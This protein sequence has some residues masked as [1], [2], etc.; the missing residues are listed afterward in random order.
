MK[1]VYSILIVGIFCIPSFGKI[2]TYFSN[3]DVLSHVLESKK[4]AENK[5]LKGLELVSVEVEREGKMLESQYT[6]SLQYTALGFSL[7]TCRVT[8][9]VSIEVRT[10]GIGGTPRVTVSE[11]TDPKLKVDCAE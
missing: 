1:N 2:R 4:L 5:R 9:D 6:L 10:L 11:L 3:A 7:K 8:A